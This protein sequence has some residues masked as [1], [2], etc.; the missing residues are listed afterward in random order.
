[1]NF[2]STRGGNSV[3]SAAKAIAQ[4]LADDGGLFV[5]ERFPDLSKKLKDMLEMDY[6]ERAALVLSSFLEEY[7]KE[8]L[9]EA[10]RKAYGKFEEEDAAPLIKIDDKF[11]ILELFHGPTLAFKDIAL[12]ILPYLLREGANKAG[13]KEEILILVATSGDTGKA[14]LEGF[15]DQEG[16]KITVF[17]PDEGVSDMQKLQMSTQEGNNV[18]VVAVKGNFDDCQ[19]AVKNIFTNK[20]YIKKLKEENV[21]LSSANSINF[22]RLS[23]QIAYYFSAYC[24][25]VNGE[26]IEFGDVVDFVVPTGNFGNILAGYYAKQMGLPVGKLVCASNDNKILTDFFTTGSYDVNR[27]FFKTI[28]PSMDILISSN[29][30]RL[31]FEFSGRNAE[32]TKKR[33]E[34][35]K[36]DGVYTISEEEKAEIEKEFY[37][38]FTSE[39]ASRNTIKNFFEDYDY[40]LDTHTAVA[41]EVSYG[42]QSTVETDNA[43]VI[44]STASPYKFAADVLKSL[45]GKE[46]LDPFKASEKLE[47][48]TAMPIPDKIKELKNK[49]IRFTKVLKSEEL[50]EEVLNFVK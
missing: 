7:D 9:L 27:E 31:I 20:E 12:T 37:A 44:V 17:Y 23:P 5:P 41:V 24:D 49:P 16:I 1:M 18:N 13:I 46:E 39:D 14:A 10:C 11:Y 30:E 26:E 43:L 21:I 15:K 45:T 40:A 48:E 42:Y 25:L 19:T 32:L 29:L 38:D 28:S 35:L 33:M 22:G 6:P 3:D 4:G 34:E 8:G 2:I 47:K 50:F 36:K